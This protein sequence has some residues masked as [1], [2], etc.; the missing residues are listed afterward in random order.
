MGQLNACSKVKDTPHAHLL[1]R[2]VGCQPYCRHSASWKYPLCK[3]KPCSSI[4]SALSHMKMHRSL[5]PVPLLTSV[6]QTILALGLLQQCVLFTSPV[7]DHWFHSP[8]IGYRSMEWWGFGAQWARERNSYLLRGHV[9]KQGCFRQYCKAKASKAG[10]QCKERSFCIINIV[11]SSE[12]RDEEGV[13]EFIKWHW[14]VWNVWYGAQKI[15]SFAAETI[16]ERWVGCVWLFSGDGKQILMMSTDWPI[17][18]CVYRAL[19]AKDLMFGGCL[20]YV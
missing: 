17:L 8:L 18:S 3:T 1:G 13:D 15:C 5:P 10:R 6:V 14:K 19:N 12:C 9:F 20:Q 4:R 2:L 16:D 7:S 11:S